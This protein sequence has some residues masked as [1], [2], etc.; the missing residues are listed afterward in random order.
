VTIAE[1]A[2]RPS[3]VI[4]HVSSAHCSVGSLPRQSHPFQ[5]PSSHSCKLHQHSFRSV[6]RLHAE[7]ISTQAACSTRAGRALTAARQSASASQ[8]DVSSMRRHSTVCLASAQESPAAAD[9][10]QSRKQKRQKLR[11]ERSAGRESYRPNSFRTIIADASNAVIS[12]LDDGL[13]R[14]EVELPSVGVDSTFPSI[15]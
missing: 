15:P 4:G 6:V 12:G 3:S 14:L 8:C 7:C 11:D 1:P 13:T 10:E 5:Y 9:Q 2:M